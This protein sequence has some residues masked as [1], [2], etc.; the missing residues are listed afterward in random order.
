MWKKINISFFMLWPIFAVWIS[1]HFSINAFLS[2]IVFYG[3]PSILLS[4]CRPTRIKKALS[5]S[6]FT[7]P[8]MIIVDYI[9]E[10]TQAWIIPK[11]ILPF[12]L[13]NYVPIEVLSW[14][15]LHA[16]IVIMFYQY[17]FEK[18]F[19]KKLWDKRS[20]EALFG[21]VFILIVFLIALFAYPSVLNIPYWYLVF[22]LLGVLPVIII[23]DLKYP[24]VFPKLLKTAIYFFY[25]NFTYEITALKLGWWSFPSRQFIGQVSFFGVTFPFEE[26]FFWIILFTL[27]LLSYYEYFFN[28]EK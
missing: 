7:I 6:L 24:N 8:F 19:V 3:G 27:A 12:R 9:A 10:S 20:K 28:K 14:I 2:T 4:I 21:T 11:S 13:F 18:K 26:F 23:E 16:Y 17:F 22:G 25:L 1:F 15:F 5:V